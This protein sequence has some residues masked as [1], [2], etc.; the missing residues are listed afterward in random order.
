MNQIYE[1]TGLEILNES[2]EVKKSK[3]INKLTKTVQKNNKFIFK[4]S[5]IDKNILLIVLGPT[6]S[7]KSSLPT[8][9]SKYL[10]INDKFKK[11][12]YIS[13]LIDDLVEINK[14]YIE[15]VNNYLD[16]LLKKYSENE[17]KNIIKNCNKHFDIINTFGFFY[18]KNRWCTNC[19]TGMRLYNLRNT[20]RDKCN[21][22]DNNIEEFLKKSNFTSRT[23]NKNIKSNK[24]TKSY[25]ESL[26]CEELND[27][28]LKIA[29]N[30]NNNILFETTGKSIPYWLFEMYEKELVNY[31]VIM[32]WSVLD[33]CE[34]IKRNKS[35]TLNQFNKWLIE[36]KEKNKINTVP[37]LPDIRFEVY[38]KDLINIIKNLIDFIK[39]IEKNNKLI[40]ENKIRILI[41]DNTDQDIDVIYDNEMHTNIKNITNE[42]YKRYNVTRK[43]CN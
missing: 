20:E 1:S 16:N 32:A 43:K 8:K 22:Y 30:N 9:V 34:L 42:I 18:K 11:G 28:K 23:L 31:K 39:E 37:R 33:I 2:R 12:N 10:F 5:Y 36:K 40:R 27:K 6:A 7:G 3:K 26:S 17:L 15:D 21:N 14:G 38:K 41:F 25:R 24:N 13:L 35:R 29:I 4:D 19:N